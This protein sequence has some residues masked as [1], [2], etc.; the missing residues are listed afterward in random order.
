[1]KTSYPGLTARSRV[2]NGERVQLWEGGDA[3]E[4]GGGELPQSSGVPLLSQPG[5]PVRLQSRSMSRLAPVWGVRALSEPEE[6]KERRKGGG[7]PGVGLVVSRQPA[8]AA[9]VTCLSTGR[10]GVLDCKVHTT[11]DEA[12]DEQ[13]EPKIATAARP[14]CYHA[15]DVRTEGGSGIMHLRLSS[16]LPCPLPRSFEELAEYLETRDVPAA[17]SAPKKWGGGLYFF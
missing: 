1:M 17:S 11:Q 9:C 15:V 5:S 3:P 10:P 13:P 6:S 2:V 7:D 14:S 4:G 12:K 8:H 16:P